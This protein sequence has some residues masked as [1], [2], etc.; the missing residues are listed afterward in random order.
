VEQ[1]EKLNVKLI[2]LRCAGYDGVDLKSALAY[3]LPVVRV[4]AYSPE[5]VAEHAAA[6]MM[7]L[8]RQ[9][10]RAY[11]RTREGNFSLEG[12]TGLD[13]HG[14]T[15][16]VIGTGRIGKSFAKI[17]KGFGCRVLMYDVYQDL[18]FAASL[19]GEYCSLDF[20]YAEADIISIHIPLFPS[21]RHMINEEAIGKMKK[22]VML[23]NTSRGAIVNTQHLLVGLESGKIGIFLSFLS[24][25]FVL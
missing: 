2:A 18:P 1:L 25:L 11:Q 10:H 14:L 24:F 21:T 7:T 19:P 5:A 4:P 6:L 20:I 15:V 9:T 16:G 8:S 13:I 17:A 23:I 3:G 12:L 22:G